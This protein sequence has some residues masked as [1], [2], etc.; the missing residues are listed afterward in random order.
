MRIHTGPIQTNSDQ[1]NQLDAF[2]LAATMEN[3]AKILLEVKRATRLVPRSFTLQLN[4]RTVACTLQRFVLEEQNIIL[5]TIPPV[6]TERVW[7][8]DIPQPCVVM[9]TRIGSERWQAAEFIVRLTGGP[10]TK[11]QLLSL[12]LGEPTSR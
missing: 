11:I 3:D 12:M 5:A 7:P 10:L 4:G 2:W 8:R 1:Q 9:F 6:E